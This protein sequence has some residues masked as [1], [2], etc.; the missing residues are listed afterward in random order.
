MEAHCSI[1]A[2]ILRNCESEFDEMAMDIANCHHENWDGSGYP[3]GLAGRDIPF[4]ARITSVADV[5]DALSSK[6]VYKEPWPDEKVTMEM[7][8]MF[9]SKFDPGLKEHFMAQLP[10]LREI[11]ESYPEN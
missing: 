11:R 2:D 10:V 7:E 9:G 5:F 6:R 3:R 1:G 8:S 4:M